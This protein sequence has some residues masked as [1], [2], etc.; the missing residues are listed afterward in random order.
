MTGYLETASVFLNVFF[1]TI[2]LFLPIN[3]SVLT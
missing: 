2:G 1:I 3:V